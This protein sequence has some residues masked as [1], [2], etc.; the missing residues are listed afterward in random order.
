MKKIRKIILLTLLLIFLLGVV[1]ATC[2]TSNN[3]KDN[4]NA[5][6]RDTT[7]TASQDNAKI[8][9]DNTKI[10]TNINDKYVQKKN[11]TKNINLKPNSN[12]NVKTAG[13]DSM[14]IIIKEGQNYNQIINSVRFMDATKEIIIELPENQKFDITSQFICGNKRNTKIFTINCN[15]S[16]FNGQNTNS[17]ITVQDGFTLNLNNVTIT[18]TTGESGCSINNSGT[19]NINNT[20]IIKN[21]GN[22]NGAIYNNGGN[23]S[24]AH[25]TLINNSAYDN[26]GAIYN[27]GTYKISDTIFYNNTP[28]NFIINENNHIKLAN[29]DNFIDIT[30][31]EITVDDEILRGVGLEEL[32]QYIIPPEAL[33][34]KLLLNGTN[35]TDNIFI[36]KET[37][38]KINIANV[39]LTN[40]NPICGDTTDIIATVIVD[41]KP[42]NEG[43]VIFRLNGK[44]IRNNNHEVIYVDITDGKA[45]LENVPIT[46]TWVEMETIVQAVFSGNDEL[47][48]IWTEKII[49]TASK[50][51]AKLEIT[52]PSTAQIGDTIT[53]STSVTNENIPINTG[54]VVFKLN[55]K[56]LKD[57]EG[58]ALYV[59]VVNGIA[60]TKYTIPSKIKSKT[61][62]L[63]AV[64]TDTTYERCEKETQITVI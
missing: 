15:G 42:I 40:E 33:N 23:L 61:Y 56:T 43:T 3:A 1:N 49:V 47:E 44:T 21:I 62:N 12:N 11:T 26:G 13:L 6:V 35:T 10:K 17:F 20:T 27:M 41:D 4:N 63:T 64:F 39:T 45:I 9:K 29:N 22:K 25:S 30:N 34:I 59:N 32:E 54:R 19:A 52:A 8:I 50:P 24:I 36:I 16:V 60:T 57:A 46:G 48:P 31:F 53:L 7:S 28:A 58:K 38:E 14:T 55:G 37:P 51:K 5:T 2:V 18:N